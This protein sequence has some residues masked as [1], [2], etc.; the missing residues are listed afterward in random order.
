MILTTT[1]NISGKKVEKTLGLVQG[2]TI[3]AKW[4]GKD[5]VA[6]LRHLVGGELVEYTE[7]LFEARSQ[8]TNRMIKQAEEKGANAI[9]S[10]RYITA[11]V[12]AG[13]A[14]ILA[15]GTAVIVK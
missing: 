4:L 3:R 1:E 14:E 11:Q 7:M 15:Y 6:G 8:A 9:I 13:A 10:V 12:S 2:N 5:F